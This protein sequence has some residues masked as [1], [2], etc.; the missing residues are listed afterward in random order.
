VRGLRRKAILAA[1]AL[2]AGEVLSTDQLADV[3][4]HPTMERVHRTI[5]SCHLS[6]R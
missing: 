2:R 1:L 6:R 5:G 4:W 3:A